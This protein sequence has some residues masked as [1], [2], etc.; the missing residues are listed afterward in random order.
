MDY[1]TIIGLEVHSQL[2]TESKMFCSCMATYQE[3]APNTTICP[4]CVGMPGT[5][6]IP[7]TVAIRHVVRTGLA[8]EC[9]ISSESKFDR[10]NYPYP[11]L[12]KGYQISQFDKPIAT[13]GCLL[14]EGIDEMTK[15]RINRV[16]LEEDV[17]KLM[18]RSNS[19]ESY[20]LLDINRSGVPL[21]EIV[22][23]PDLRSADEARDYLTSLRTI[24]RYLKVSTAN[25]EEGS[26]RCDANIS[27]RPVGDIKLGPK[28]EIKNMNSFRAVHKALTFEQKR[29]LNCKRNGERIVQETRGWSE[30]DG[31]TFSQRS[32]EHA[33]DYRYFPEPDIPPFNINESEVVEL[34]ESLPELPY[35]RRIRFIESYGLPDKEAEQLTLSKEMADYFEQVAL[36]GSVNNV[37]VHASAKAASNWLLGEMTRLLNEKST[38]ISLVKIT[39]ANLIE[40]QIMVDSKKLSSTMAKEV[41][42]QMFDTGTSPTEIVNKSGMQQIS[43]ESTLQ[44]LV[45][46]AIQINEKAVDDFLSGKETAVRFLVGQVMKLAKG[47]ANPQLAEQLVV[48]E[49]GKIRME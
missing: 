45:Q 12:M 6:P 1:E 36:L 38:E 33:H 25:M 34:Q 44:T 35:A 27:I 2:S 23:E 4:V 11:D 3:M 29:Q 22:S 32:K 17:A 7:N 39:P 42:E 46:E 28:V 13:N 10:K 37:L 15:V 43:D 40:L 5:L 30:Q 31:E 9:E 47:K 19:D 49:L 20:S 26:F 41:F 14:V 24:L 8:L 16:H 48:K 18:H 21:M